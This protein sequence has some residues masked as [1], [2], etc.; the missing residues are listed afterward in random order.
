MRGKVLSQLM[1]GKVLGQLMRGKV[2]SKLR[3]HGWLLQQTVELVQTL[4]E[5]QSIRKPA[6][7]E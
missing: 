4:T 5:R 7:Q 3:A 2:L 6:V 1:R